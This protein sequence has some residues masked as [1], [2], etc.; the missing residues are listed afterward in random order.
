MVD[1]PIFECALQQI[2]ELEDDTN[3]K[4]TTLFQKRSSSVN[5]LTDA[6]QATDSSY[7]SLKSTNQARSCFNNSVN[8]DIFQ[9]Q[10]E[11]KSFYQHSD[12]LKEIQDNYELIV[13]ENKLLRE[14]LNKLKAQHDKETNVMKQS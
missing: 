8:Q 11:M 3:K 1:H 2:L 5:L 10:L 7:L 4:L 13:S 14:R 12:M 6:N 9:V